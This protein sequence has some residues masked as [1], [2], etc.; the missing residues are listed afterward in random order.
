MNEKYPTFFLTWFNKILRVPT[1]VWSTT[2]LHGLMDLVQHVL[3][4]QF[5][6]MTYHLSRTYFSLSRH[7]KSR[8]PIINIPI[9]ILLSK[10]QA[11]EN[12]F[13][14]QKQLPL[15][16]LC[17]QSIFSQSTPHSDV[18][19][20]YTY[21]KSKLFCCRICT[22]KLT[23][24]NKSDTQFL[25]S[26]FVR[27]FG[28]P[29]LCLSISPLHPSSNALQQIGS[30]A[31]NQQTWWV[32]TPLLSCTKAWCFWYWDN[33]DIWLQMILLI[34][35]HVLWNQGY[36]MHKKYHDVLNYAIHTKMSMSEDWRW[37]KWVL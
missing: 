27:S 11:Y 24:N 2:M 35:P 23:F 31:L 8:I 16:H 37:Q 36:T 29:P 7:W 28:C 20:Q 14:T 6:T 15:L 13:T 32:N 17:T 33:G 25:F 30:C 4:L 34:A 10:P 5:N 19:Q 3:H 21:F 26:Q 9:L 22:S 12:M 1:R 18:K